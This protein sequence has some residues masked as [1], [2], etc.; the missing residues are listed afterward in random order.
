MYFLSTKDCEGVHQTTPHPWQTTSVRCVF[1]SLRACNGGPLFL[2]VDFFA[3]H[4]SSGVERNV[5]RM[6]RAA[7]HADYLRALPDSDWFSPGVDTSLPISIIEIIQLSTVR[8][9]VEHTKSGVALTQISAYSTHKN[10]AVRKIMEAMRTA[11]AKSGI[12]SRT[13]LKLQGKRSR[14]HT[15]IVKGKRASFANDISVFR[16]IVWWW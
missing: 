16:W 6:R 4:E 2:H 11:Y 13:R 3:C 9:A 15:S 12:Q 5:A 14:R 1:I 8:W 10:L 7:Q